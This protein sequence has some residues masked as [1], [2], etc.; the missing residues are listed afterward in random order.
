MQNNNSVTCPKVDVNLLNDFLANLGPSTVAN[1]NS[2]GADFKRFIPH[3]INSFFLHS[4]DADEIIKVCQLL[5]PKLSSGYDQLPIKTMCGIIDLISH[6]LAYLFNLSFSNSIFPSCF[7]IAKV[8]PLYKGDDTSKLINFRPISIF[9]SLS[10][11]FERI[12]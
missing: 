1:M 2:N 5:K 8:V 10:N 12:M 11:V 6:P 3:S 9:P 7:K 4:T